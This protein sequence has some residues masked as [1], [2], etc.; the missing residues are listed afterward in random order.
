ML[1]SDRGEI[2]VR[3]RYLDELLLQAAIQAGA[4]ARQNASVLT[5][6][7]DSGGWQVGFQLGAEGRSARAPLLIAADGRNSTVARLIG[8]RGR[9][10][11][12]RDRVG[13][14]THVARTP[15]IARTDRANA[16]AGRRL[17]G[18]LAPV[19]NGLLNVSL[20]G[21]AGQIDALKSWAVGEFGP[22]DEWRTIAPAGPVCISAGA[23][24]WLVP[25]RRRRAR[26]GAIHRR[27]NLL[28]DVHRRTGGRCGG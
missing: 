15:A 18:G 14:Q 9:R 10:G 25:A 17:Y 4:Q 21:Q 13:L 5:V 23:C 27:G 11:S 7:R 20:A 22:I 1:Q 19:G 6:A 2:A 8:L 28:R 12:S 26:R 3:R 24:G 16:L